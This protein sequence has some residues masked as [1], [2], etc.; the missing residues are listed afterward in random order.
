MTGDSADRWRAYGV[1]GS[2]LLQKPFN[3]FN[4]VSTLATALNEVDTNMLR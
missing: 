4:L 2:K 1:P 3:E